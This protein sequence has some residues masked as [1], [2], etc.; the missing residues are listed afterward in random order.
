MKRMMGASLLLICAV[1]AALFIER[2]TAKLQE[3]QQ[4]TRSGQPETEAV[5]PEEMSASDMA[6]SM[7]VVSAA[8]YYL[9]SEDGKLVVY[10][11][12]KKTV[13]C[14]TS[15]KVENLPKEVRDALKDGISFETDAQLYEFLENY[16][17]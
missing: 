5:E 9:G 14:D 8:K 10:L 15:I 3:E 2:D 6:E 1:A 4:Q 11:S 17:S 12:D 7:T 16:S 13:Y